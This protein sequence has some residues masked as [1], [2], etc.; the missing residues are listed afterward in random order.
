M[1][2]KSSVLLAFFCAMCL[3]I[4][5]MPA[6][7]AQATRTWVSGVG[8][9]VNPCSRTAPCK[10][11]AGTIT[12]TAAGGEIN[13]LDS[14]GFGGVTITKAITIFCRGVTGGVLGAG[15]TVV[16]GAS[17]KVVLDGLDFEGV[18]GG[19]TGVQV[20][21]GAA[22]YIL[23]TSIRDYPQN[24]V[25]VTSS[26]SGT[27]VFIRDSFIENNGGGGVNVHGSVPNSASIVNTL[28]DGNGAYAI[29]VNTSNDTIAIA[30]SVLSGTSV[31]ISNAGGAVSSFGPS[32]IIAGSGA[33]TVTNAFK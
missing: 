19:T 16:A 20:S 4:L 18:G 17:D 14:G 28:I 7:N 32:N 15:I 22:V 29:Q 10:T 3:T 25:N 5:S 1:F 27:R 33:P 8:D 26:T 13:C 6:A 21:S 11:F 2:M 12:K 24:G 30:N 9:D 23:H 31:A